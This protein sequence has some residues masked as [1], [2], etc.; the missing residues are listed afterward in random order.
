MQLL[1]TVKGFFKV[2][3]VT[4]AEG[5]EHMQT[6]AYRTE[7]DQKKHLAT[8]KGGI[9]VFTPCTG[10]NYIDRVLRDNGYRF[11]S[12]FCKANPAT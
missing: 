7:I 6:V 9:L 5:L 3:E 4:D 10:A 11:T 2:A 1:P 8:I 12:M